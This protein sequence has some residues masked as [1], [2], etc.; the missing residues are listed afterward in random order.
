[1]LKAFHASYRENGPKCLAELEAIVPLTRLNAIRSRGPLLDDILLPAYNLYGKAIVVEAMAAQ[2]AFLSEFTGVDIRFHN[3]V[4][5]DCTA[6]A[7]GH[8]FFKMQKLK[9]TL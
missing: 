6:P 9:P 7:E 2:A 8:S 1:M 5:S 3:L 4:D